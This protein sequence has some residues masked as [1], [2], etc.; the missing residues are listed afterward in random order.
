MREFPG[1]RDVQEKPLHDTARSEA[2]YGPP[3]AVHQAAYAD[4]YDV[5]ASGSDRIEG[6]YTEG[7]EPREH[8]G[9]KGAQNQKE[10]R[11]ATPTKRLREGIRFQDV[12]G[13]PRSE[14]QKS[15][16]GC[17]PAGTAN[18]RAYP[19]DSAGF[20]LL[21]RAEL[22]DKLGRR[23]PVANGASAVTVSSVLRRIENRP[24]SS[25]PRR[26]ATTIPT[27]NVPPAVKAVATK[28]Q[29]RPARMRG[30]MSGE[31]ASL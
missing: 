18:P 19:E 21:T 31:T 16:R 23:E 9:L 7:F 1:A 4:E 11:G 26:F 2:D 25:R 28:L 12:P 24:K 8:S 6:E 27:T 30:R 5:Q 13:K 29:R 20:R 10:R 15:P 22:R 14:K 17:Q 3:Q